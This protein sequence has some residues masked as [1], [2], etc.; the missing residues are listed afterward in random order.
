MVTRLG[1][2][3]RRCRFD[4]GLFPQGG[5]SFRFSPSPGHKNDEPAADRT[6]PCCVSKWGAIRG[7]SSAVE[8]LHAQSCMQS[9]GG[10]N[11]SFPAG[12]RTH[13][14]EPIG[15]NIA[16]GRN[17]E[18]GHR[19]SLSCPAAGLSTYAARR[20]LLGCPGTSPPMAPT[21]VT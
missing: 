11:P 12:G 3:P 4:S 8:R 20:F 9:V 7:S 16:V 15:M 13:P 10:S 17:E 1:G 6:H 19:I 2:F 18:R 14:R 21:K 5:F